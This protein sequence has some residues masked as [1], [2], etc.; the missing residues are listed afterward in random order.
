MLC[1]FIAHIRLKLNLMLSFDRVVKYVSVA[2]RGGGKGV[3]K[4]GIYT[5]V[6]Y[7]EKQ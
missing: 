2:Y 4:V 3:A 6:K 1:T 5:N 7:I